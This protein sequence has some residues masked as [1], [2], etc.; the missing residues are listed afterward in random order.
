VQLELD[1][2]FGVVETCSISHIMID[3]T[4]DPAIRSWVLIPVMV[5]MVLFM[6]ARRFLDEF[7]RSSPEKKK[8]AEEETQDEHA[9]VMKQGELLRRTARL[10]AASF[11]L[12]PESFGARREQLVEALQDAE[13]TARDPV[14]PML[15]P[16]QMGDVM[17]GNISAM[18]PSVLMMGVFTTFFSGFVLVKFPFPLFEGLRAIVQR[19]INLSGLDVEYATSLSVYFML[20]YGLGGIMSLLFSGKEPAL[21]MN[22]VMAQQ[23]MMPPMMAGMGGAGQGVRGALENERE[24]LQLV[25]HSFALHDAEMRLLNTVEESKKS[26]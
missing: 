11:M 22:Q 19:D 10:R 17:K 13:K 6:A 23:M 25:D 14:N 20:L 15:D 7:L 12:R 9:S 1:S 2:F 3:L 8:S 16:T 21:D 26:R 18:V 4:L 24:Y 5:M